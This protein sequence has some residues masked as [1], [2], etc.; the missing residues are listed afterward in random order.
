[1]TDKRKEELLR[2]AL[3]CISRLESGRRLYGCLHDSMGMANTEIEE[4][5][6]T[7][8]EYYEEDTPEHMAA[9]SGRQYAALEAWEWRLKT[10]VERTVW[11]KEHC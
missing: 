5:G 9:A 2:R 3:E 1:M 11:I 7:L 8:W 6:Y 4:A 10:A